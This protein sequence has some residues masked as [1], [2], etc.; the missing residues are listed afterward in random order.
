MI[1]DIFPELTD[2]KVF[3]KADLKDGFLQIQLDEESSKLTMFQTPWGR[4]RYLRMPFG[5]SPAPEYFQRKL[6]QNLEGLNGIYKIADDILITGRGASIDEAVKDH[7]VN[8]RKLLDRCRKRNLKLNR[9]KLQLKCSETPFI[10]HVLT[11]EGV[12]PDPR[13][14]DAILKME[15]PNNVA[16][17]RRLI[18]L[19]NYLSKFLSK[20]SELC[21]PLR[22]LTHKDV[23]WS[24]SAVQEEAFQSIKRAVTSAPVLRY[25]NSAEPVEGQGDASSSGIGF[26]LMQN[27]QPVSYSSTYSQ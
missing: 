21:E 25:F 11:P 14:V 2:V 3:S 12:K 19:A 16:A 7:D 24:W 4:Y 5:I 18:G 8:L 23:E 26:V 22:R 10:G 13:K 17:V 6:D 1:E 15:R 20:L 27:G 9:E